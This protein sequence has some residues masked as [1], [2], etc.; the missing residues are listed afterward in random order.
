MEIDWA[1]WSEAMELVSCVSERKV[2]GK[3]PEQ[4][5][6]LSDNGKRLSDAQKV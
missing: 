1:D 6:R 4:V 2:L 3:N 5:R